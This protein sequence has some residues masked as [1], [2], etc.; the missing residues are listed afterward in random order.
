[1][2][3]QYRKARKQVR[4]RL[5]DEELKEKDFPLAARDLAL[6]KE[7]DLT[8]EILQPYMDRAKAEM[9]KKRQAKK[10]SE[11]PR[12]ETGSGPS[13]DSVDAEVPVDDT[14]AGASAAQ[15]V[16]NVLWAAE[17]LS[18]ENVTNK[19]AP[20]RTAWALLCWAR[21]N[22][23]N[24]FGQLYKN[25]VLPSRKELEETRDTVEDSERL[26]RTLEKV[27]VAMLKTD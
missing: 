4:W 18:N 22:P 10:E 12:T 16:T 19:D 15:N 5:E 13:V 26:R 17:N 23:D 1:M 11:K 25:V 24:F 8:D 20:T 14:D 2:S 27:K 21:K 9:R 6:R 7:F 3:P